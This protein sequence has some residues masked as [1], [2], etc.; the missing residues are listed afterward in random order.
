MDLQLRGPQMAP[1][2]A[3]RMA[4][5]GSASRRHEASYDL[6]MGVPTVPTTCPRRP[7]AQSSDR[8]L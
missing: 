2:M 8:A 1:Q 6:D 3:L 4:P 7:G 5:V